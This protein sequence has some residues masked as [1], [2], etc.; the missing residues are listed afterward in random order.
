MFPFSF[1]CVFRRI[2]NQKTMLRSIESE[3][4]VLN[5]TTCSL[6]L[7]LEHIGTPFP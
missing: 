2:S 4:S 7:L 1:S 6:R 3:K 5:V